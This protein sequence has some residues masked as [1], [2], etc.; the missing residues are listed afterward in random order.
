MVC[1]ADALPPTCNVEPRGTQIPL[2]AA[3]NGFQ[4]R[5]ARYDGLGD[6]AQCRVNSEA[7]VFR[8]ASMDGDGIVATP[9]YGRR[10]A[11]TKNL[12]TLR[13]LTSR[14]RLDCATCR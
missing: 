4:I 1:N 13:L 2:L 6:C 3:T 9:S 10:P 14:F 12:R 7:H 11:V 5:R 8:R